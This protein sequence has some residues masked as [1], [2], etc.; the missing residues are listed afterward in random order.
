MSLKPLPNIFLLSQFA[1]TMNRY[2]TTKRECQPKVL[3]FKRLACVMNSAAKRNSNAYL[4]ANSLVQV[5][6]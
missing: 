4:L 1:K 6:S 3:I 5:L 2:L